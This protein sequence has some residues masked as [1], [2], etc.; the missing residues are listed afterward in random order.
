MSGYLPLAPEGANTADW[1]I[2][3][4]VGADWI[5]NVTGGWV[6]L[7]SNTFSTLSKS[8]SHSYG[9][10]T[11]L[12]VPVTSTWRI[13]V[14][15]SVLNGI[16]DGFCGV[17]V[18]GVIHNLRAFTGGPNLVQGSD[19]VI[20]SITAGAAIRLA[21]YVI[22]GSITWTLASTRIYLERLKAAV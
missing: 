11:L 18:G 6:S 4:P 1:A 13:T 12:T 7:T 3:Q 5:N 19:S 14:V 10:S 17:N 16:S 15:P 2:I 21:T 9:T 20:V 22:S 8:S